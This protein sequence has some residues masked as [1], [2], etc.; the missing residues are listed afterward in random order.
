MKKM[1]EILLKITKIMEIFVAIILI[2]AIALSFIIIMCDICGFKIDTGTYQLEGFLKMALTLVVGIEFVKML[3]LHTPESVL[4]VL[5]YAVARQ[6]VIYHESALEN[7]I[8]VIAV[9]V[10]F[11]I[12]KYFG[13]PI[14]K[15]KE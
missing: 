13:T 2:L 4:E 11:V 9:G 1:L 3:I 5:L 8:G 10:V 14:K 6:I 12:R 15:D 7:L